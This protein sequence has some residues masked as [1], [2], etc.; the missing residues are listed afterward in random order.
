MGER[1]WF[2]VNGRRGSFLLALSLVHIGVGVYVYQLHHLPLESLTGGGIVG[3]LPFI[4][5]LGVPIVAASVPWFVSALIAVAAAFVRPPGKDGFGFVALAL[6]E[7]VWALVYVVG[8]TLGARGPATWFL[9][10]VFAAMGAAVAIVSGMVSASAV[11]EVTRART[12]R[13]RRDRAT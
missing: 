13:L 12:A 1:A 11:Q 2:G 8:W 4:R 6:M 9:A 7:A 5:A 3:P 10:L